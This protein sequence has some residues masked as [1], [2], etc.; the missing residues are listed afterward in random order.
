[1]KKK[2]TSV[3]PAAVIGI[4]VLLIALFAILLSIKPER[5]AEMGGNG[6]GGNVAVTGNT[7]T[8]QSGFQIPA[9]TGSLVTV[10]NNNEPFFTEEEKALRKPFEQYSE[11]DWLGRCGPAFALVNKELMPTDD[12]EQI[13]EVTP[14]GWHQKEYTA[15]DGSSL[16]AYERCHLIA[17]CLSGENANEKNLITGTHALNVGDPPGGRGEGGMLPYETEIAQYCDRGYSC[18]VRVTPCFKTNELV[19]RG[20]LYEAYSIETDEIRTCVFIHNVSCSGP[21]EERLFI[22]DYLNGYTH[23]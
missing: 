5:S 3:A 14:S 8:V 16:W 1:M 23:Q 12:R 9:Y 6:T 18:L 22:I 10:I 20:V 19:A 15:P 21:E 2:S 17:F 11:L 7:E 4:I 13:A